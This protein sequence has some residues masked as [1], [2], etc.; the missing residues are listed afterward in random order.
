MVSLIYY[1]TMN[2]LLNNEHINHVT[3]VAGKTM[4]VYALVTSK[5]DYCNSVL[6]GIPDILLNKFWNVQKSA[7]R[8]ITMSE[9]YQHISPTM[10][11]L[12]WLP[13]WQRIEYKI[14]LLTYKALNNLAPLYLSDLLQCRVDWGFRRDNTLLLVY[15]KI[16]RVTFGSRAFFKAA[17]MLWNSIPPSLRACSSVAQFKKNLK[18]HLCHRIYDYSCWRFLI[19]HITIDLLVLQKNCF[20]CL[21]YELIL[22]CFYVLYMN[23]F[24]LSVQRLRVLQIWRYRNLT[25]LLS[26][27]WL[28]FYSLPTFCM[29][30]MKV[31]TCSNVFGYDVRPTSLPQLFTSLSF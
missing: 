3:E 18:T 15:P 4:V 19:F 24:Y 17:P 13:I 9:K 28:L 26:L 12:H 27:L 5:L 10:K 1:S 30:T 16:N 14:L 11:K 2:I 31:E 21:L 23:R 8:L 25:L 29:A 6:Y 7:A 20:I 22:T